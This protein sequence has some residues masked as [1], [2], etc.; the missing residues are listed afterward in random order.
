MVSSDPVRRGASLASVH[1]EAYRASSRDENDDNDLRAG[2]IEY[3]ERREGDMLR[4]VGMIAE[5]SGR[6]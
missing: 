3:L 2:I 1:R 6:A 5:L 4:S